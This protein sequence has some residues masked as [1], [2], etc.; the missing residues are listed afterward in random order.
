MKTKV[1]ELTKMPVDDV[2]NLPQGCAWKGCRASFKGEMPSGWVN[3]ITYWAKEPQTSFMDIPPQDIRRDTAL[4]PQHAR[5]LESYLFGLSS[6][7]L[8]GK[9]H[10]NA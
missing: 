2:G 4:C 10:G 6:P 7:A 3:L 8:R 5:E 1:S 9:P